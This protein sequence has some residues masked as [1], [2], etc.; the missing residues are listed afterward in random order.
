MTTTAVKIENQMDRLL[1][2]ADLVHRH[3]EL[4]FN[5]LGTT[6]TAVDALKQLRRVPFLIERQISKAIRRE[7]HSVV[8]LLVRMQCRGLVST[9]RVGA[10]VRVSITLAGLEL[11]GLVDTI[12]GK[13]AYFDYLDEER[14]QELSVC[15]ERVI[16][17][18]RELL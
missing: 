3:R 18:T 8:A 2:A 5:K 9:E 17:R 16:E 14:Q 7:P 13:L 4:E 1:E 6:P 15:L 12:D 10:T 11:L